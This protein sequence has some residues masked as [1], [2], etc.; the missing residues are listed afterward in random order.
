MPTKNKGRNGKVEI[1]IELISTVTR[2]EFHATS[3]D[4]VDEIKKIITLLEKKGLAVSADYYGVNRNPHLY[5]TNSKT[6]VIEIVV[7]VHSLNAPRRHLADLP[8]LLEYFGLT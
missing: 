1:G 3:S 4:E 2:I 7:S 6:V 5:P 8:E